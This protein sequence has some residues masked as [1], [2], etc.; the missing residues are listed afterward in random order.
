MQVALRGFFLRPPVSIF[1][2][3]APKAWPVFLSL[4]VPSRRL[5]GRAFFAPI[6]KDDSDAGAVYLKTPTPRRRAAGRLIGSV[7]LRGFVKDVVMVHSADW[8]RA[9]GARR[10]P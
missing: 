4:N 5:A 9:V 1:H 3:C 10:N 8:P 2:Y 6:D 7:G